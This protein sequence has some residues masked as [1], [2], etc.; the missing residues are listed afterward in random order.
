MQRANVVATLE[1]S[2][3]GV[4][5]HA[6]RD[7]EIEDLDVQACEIAASYYE[8]APHLGRKTLATLLGTCLVD[9]SEDQPEFDVLL[10]YL[11]TKLPQDQLLWDALIDVM[12]D[13]LLELWAPEKLATLL[14]DLADGQASLIE[15]ILPSLVRASELDF[16]GFPQRARS[17]VKSLGRNTCFHALLKSA[18][19]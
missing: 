18:K 3:I 12:Q 11:R 14:I 15:P 6:T 19:K 10:A 4:G 17:L 13:D 16:K 8:S 7:A 2:R 5:L 9:L 1:V